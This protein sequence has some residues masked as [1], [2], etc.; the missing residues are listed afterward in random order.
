[1]DFKKIITNEYRNIDLIND[2]IRDLQ[3]K[4]DECYLKI[5]N[6]KKTFEKDNSHFIGKKALCSIDGERDFQNVECT[7]TKIIVTDNFDIKP[8]FVNKRNKKVSVDFYDWL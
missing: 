7:C 1:M 2:K 8:L 6:Y 4:K 3:K 5:S